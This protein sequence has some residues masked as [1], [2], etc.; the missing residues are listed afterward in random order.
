MA[1]SGSYYVDVGSHWR[2]Q[3]EWS[4]SQSISGNYSNVTAR[5]YWI[6]RDNYGAVRSSAT[7]TVGL[8]INGGWVYGTASAS[9]SGNQKKLIMQRT[10]IINHNSD[11]TASF[12]LDGLFDAEVT[13]GGTYYG[14]IEMPQR[15][16]TL[17]TIPRAS[18]MTTPA[19]IIAGSD[20]TISISRAS[21]SFYHYADISVKNVS[22]NWIDIKSVYFSTSQTSLSTSFSTAQKKLIFQALGQ[23]SSAESRIVIRT[24]G[25]GGT[26]IGSKTYTGTIINPSA[27]VL[28]NSFDHYVYVDQTITGSLVSKNSEFTHTIRIELGSFTKTISNVKTSFS[29]TPSASEQQSLYSQMPNSRV[30]DGKIYVTTYYDGVQVR[31]TWNALLQFHVRNSEP[32]FSASNI[33][34]KDINSTTV[35]LTGN[36]QYIIQ[37]KSNLRAYINNGATPRNQSS[38]TKYEISINGVTRSITSTGYIDMGAIDAENDVTLTVRA[39]DS[40]GFS[41]SVSKTVKIV[42]YKPPIVNTRA[43]RNNGFEENTKLSLSGSLS[44]VKIGDSN[45]NSLVSSRYRYKKSTDSVFSAWYSFSVTGFPNYEAT[46]K[47]LTLDILHEWDIQVEVVDKLGSTLVNIAVPVG[48]PIFY[49]DVKN[50]SVS[51]NTLPK[52]LDQTTTRG[53]EVGGGLYVRGGYFDLNSYSDDYGKGR[54]QSYFDANAKRWKIYGRT[55]DYGSSYIDIDL[56]G[57][58]K[59][60]QENTTLASLQNGWENYSSDDKGF[61]RC[62]YWKDKNGIVHVG[63]L[64]RNGKTNNDT[65]LFQLPVGYRPLGTLIFLQPTA[66]AV[67]GGAFARVD[68]TSSGLVVLRNGGSSPQAWLSLNM[69][70]RA[71]Y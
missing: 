53:L 8:N 4:A 69:S 64:I 45:K 17:N 50:K 71:F 11:G 66:G 42:P 16:F 34:Y 38:I 28:S 65:T 48:Q 68:I 23:R 51:V 12:Y 14:R 59:F 49:I 15:T 13:L 10:E 46:S 47:D 3:L 62:R 60:I 32:T 43:S 37:G 58:G 26:Y 56:L 39:I 9:L 27:T 7:K 22:G 25:S 63:G 55:E 41:T 54:I 1:L 67:S 57:D 40:R 52:I 6:A 61:Y 30:R 5:L 44:P 33:S 19:N 35:N 20:R 2:L 18:S 29:W 24:Y 36:D 70:F 21:T 31:P